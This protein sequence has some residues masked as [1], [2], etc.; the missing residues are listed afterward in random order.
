MSNNTNNNHEHAQKK[1]RTHSFELCTPSS[2]SSNHLPPDTLITVFSFLHAH[3]VV[4]VCSRVC[5]EWR[6]I[7]V[8]DDEKQD[9][10]DR[11]RFEML[12]KQLYYYRWG[13]KTMKYKKPDV[14]WCQEYLNR[15]KEIVK[16]CDFCQEMCSFSERVKDRPQFIKPCK[17]PDGYVH[18]RCWNHTRRYK[19]EEFLIVKAYRQTLPYQQCIHCGTKYKLQE[20]PLYDNGKYISD[21]ETT[22]RRRL[23]RSPI[24]LSAAAV[25]VYALLNRCNSIGYIGQYPFY[26]MVIVLVC[27]WLLVMLIIVEVNARF[28]NDEMVKRYHLHDVEISPD[29]YEI[30]REQFLF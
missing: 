23:N 3:Q 30:H 17:C 21:K 26:F 29:S 25:A 1:K 13:G 9:N 20:D 11:E 24:V 6:T 28:F 5:S 16:P 12:W 7:I 15:V 10:D 14:N 22:A 4:N 18:A 27:M 2:S 19:N 8:K